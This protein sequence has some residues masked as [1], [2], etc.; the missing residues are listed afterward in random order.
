[1][2]WKRS[3][4]NHIHRWL[5]RWGVRIS[6]ISSSELREASLHVVQHTAGPLQ[7]LVLDRGDSVQ[8]EHT[9]GR[10]YER[11]ELTLLEKHF[12]GGL[13]V[14]VGANVGNHSLWCLHLCHPQV[15]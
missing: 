4:L 1:M 5:R 13:V 7:M 9:R 2:L 11:E 6:R 14:D 15:V 12:R 8:G 3:L 10:L